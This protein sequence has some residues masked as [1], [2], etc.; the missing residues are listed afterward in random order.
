MLFHEGEPAEFWWVLVDGSIDLVRHVGREDNVL[1]HDGRAGPLGR[2]FPGLGRA[3]RLPRDRPRRV[4]PAGCSG[5]LP[6]CCASGR[7]AGS[8]SAGT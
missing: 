5:C 6:R 7:S 1:G 2:R 8:P 4:A 3:G